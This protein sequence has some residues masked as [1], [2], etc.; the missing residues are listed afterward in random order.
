MAAARWYVGDTDQGDTLCSGGGDDDDADSNIFQVVGRLCGSYT[1]TPTGYGRTAEIHG[2]G[3]QAYNSSNNNHISASWPSVCVTF[4]NS[5][6]TSNNASIAF[7]SAWNNTLQ[8]V[9]VWLAQPAH[10]NATS[11]EFKQITETIL[12]TQLGPAAGGYYALT[13]GGCNNVPSSDAQF[14]P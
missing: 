10:Q 5:I 6:Q 7:N 11:I 1:F 8:L 14:C 2:L 12:R 4:G 9:D 3:T 13:I